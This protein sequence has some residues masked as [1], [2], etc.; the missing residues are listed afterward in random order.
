M[1]IRLRAKYVSLVQISAADVLKR[2]K[3]NY[4]RPGDDRKPVVFHD[5]RTVDQVY[6]ELLKLPATVHLDEID[7]VIGNTSWTHFT[8]ESCSASVRTVV[9]IG[10]YEKRNYCPICVHEAFTLVT[11]AAT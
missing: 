6:K 10:E 8:C 11:E 3:H 1:A 9:E 7:K 5:G 4:C 2:W